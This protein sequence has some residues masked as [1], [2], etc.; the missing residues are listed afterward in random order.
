MIITP[1]RLVALCGI[2]LNGRGP[3]EVRVIPDE[4]E[5][6]IIRD[7]RRGELRGLPHFLRLG[8]FLVFILAPFVLKL[9]LGGRLGALSCDHYCL[10]GCPDVILQR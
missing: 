4:R 5:E 7:I 10:I 3:F 2:L 8:V 1:Q 9:S 6:S